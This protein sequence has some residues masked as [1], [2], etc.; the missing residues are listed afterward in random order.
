[1]VSREAASPGWV[2][3][4]YLLFCLLVQASAG[5][6]NAPFAG[7]PDEPAHFVGSVML[8]DYLAGGLA[9]GP[10]DFARN[11][12]SHYPYFAVGYWPPLF[13]AI[14]GFWF[15]IAGV[16]RIQALLIQA[17]AA[18]GMAW[19][20]YKLTRKRAGPV[21]GFCAGLLLLSLPDTRSL[22]CA[23]MADV[24]TA[25]FCLAAAACLIRYFEE[26][27]Y[28]NGIYFALCAACAVL[29]K[30]SGLYICALPFAALV[31]LR[32]LDLLRRPS[33]LS[34]PLLVALA[35][36]PWAV[37]SARFT[38]V[39]LPNQPVGLAANRI[40]SFSI[41]VFRLFPPVLAAVVVLG[42][43]ALIALP[44]VW[45]AD[46]AV[47]ALMYPCLVVF[48][49]FS[50]VD[51]ERRYLLAGAAGLL[52]LSSA[53][54]AAFVELLPGRGGPWARA[55]PWL[56]L[57]LTLTATAKPLLDHPTAPK[58]PT[59]SVVGAIVT[60]PVWAGK[61]IVVAPGLEGPMIAEFAAQ[62]RHRPGYELKRPN[63]IFATMDW[64]GGNYAC[65]FQSSAEMM[66]YLREH[67][68]DLIVWRSGPIDGLSMHER[69]MSEMLRDNPL[70][71]RRVPWSGASS[72]YEIYEYVPAPQAA[73]RR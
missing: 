39:G 67:P 38:F 64:F 16:G 34:Q 52:A 44:R 46:V 12:Y 10:L 61:K 13:Y 51:P 9:S 25:F 56:C 24:P 50:P 59:R 53:G 21:I 32:R 7:F 30:Y 35:V 55:V 48:L 27:T 3:A 43:F 58:W 28:R 14:T 37:Y 68:V 26:T 71:W 22:L 23:V 54:W 41:E 70:A 17:G 65:R 60:N 63:K 69:L 8:R 6:W 29:T 31:C 1:M 66:A 45:R 36:G 57:A 49:V 73:A 42:L 62:D 15:L 18:A 72:S 33:F 2:A 20:V 11:Y 19:L 40:V 4:A 5:A 47:L